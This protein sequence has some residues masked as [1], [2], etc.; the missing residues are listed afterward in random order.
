VKEANYS[1]FHQITCAFRKEG[2][3]RLKGMESTMNI[4]KLVS[5]NMLRRPGRF[6]FTLLG[7]T[8]GMASFV[9]LLSMG[10]NLRSEV[11]QQ[12]DALGAHLVVMSRTN[13]PFVMMSVLTGDQMPEAIPREVVGQ[14]AALDGVSTAVP[15]LTIGAS[16][17]ETLVTLTGILPAEMKE[18]RNWAVQAG[19]Y[20]ANDS[21]S[22]VIGAG[23]ATKFGLSIGDTLTF[24]GVDFPIAAILYST[25][26]NDDATVFMPLNIIQQIFGLGD[27]VS[28]IAVTL[29]D[30]TKVE[31]YAAAIL[32]FA[33]VTVTTDEELLG[34]VLLILGSVNVTLQLIAGVAL[35]AAAFGIINTMMTAIYER[36]REIGILRAMGSKSRVIFQIF[37]IESG[38]YG[39]F[40]GLL[41]LAVGFVVSR[42]AAP[43][44]Q[45]NQFADVLGTP[46]ATVT[47]SVTL[48][49][50]V[51]GLSVL[52]SIVSGIY[53][54]WKASK[55]T[56]MEAIRNV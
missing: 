42:F 33:N 41:G 9:A 26:S 19:N 6:I 49:L 12:A 22:V 10:D 24:R 31:Q 30:V 15:Y 14:I 16:I 5:K 37:I 11:T 13:C 25:S 1:F 51:L 34:S 45:Q 48:V 56:P 21:E 17:D 7:I 2:F 3:A 50:I 18:H 44:I 43:F 20:F 47:L 54:A 53:P 23:V 55:L 52:I 28:F 38:L 4:A 29:N 35:I 39:L 40:G 8:I 32:D 36:R 46:D 27:Y